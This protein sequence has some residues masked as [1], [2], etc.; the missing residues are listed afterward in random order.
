MFTVKNSTRTIVS[1]A[2][3]TSDDSRAIM[4]ILSVG[5]EWLPVGIIEG[6][7]LIDVTLSADSEDTA[8]EAVTRV[9][10][11]FSNFHNEPSDSETA[12]LNAT[13]VRP[14]RIET[15]KVAPLSYL[16]WVTY[17]GAEIEEPEEEELDYASWIEMT[18]D[19]HAR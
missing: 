12:L 8:A 3:L 6:K 1:L 18:N 15:I 19:I 4:N 11:M 2:T 5:T 7:T 16:T 14:K 9:E 17:R 10:D 13:E